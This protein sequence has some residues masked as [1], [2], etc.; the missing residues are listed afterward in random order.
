MHASVVG[1]AGV[2]VGT[3]VG[4]GVGVGVGVAHGAQGAARASDA[5]FVAYEPVVG[6]GAEVFDAF[7][8]DVGE[9][10]V[11]G[12]RFV[13]I[14][15]VGR[16]FG[17]AVCDFMAADIECHERSVVG[18]VA[19]AIGHA[20]T[21]PEGVD[22]VGRV[23]DVG[24]QLGSVAVVGVAVVLLQVVGVHLLGAPMS[25]HADRI[26]REVGGRA[27]EV[28]G[29]VV[30]GAVVEVIGFHAVAAARLA[31]AIDGAGVVGREGD[32]AVVEAGAGGGHVGVVDA[33]VFEDHMAREGIDEHPGAV[34]GL[35]GIDV[36][37]PCQTRGRLARVVGQDDEFAFRQIGCVLL[38]HPL[39]G[40]YVGQG[41]FE[42]LLFV[43]SR[44]HGR[45]GHVYHVG[46]DGFHLSVAHV[47]REGDAL[48][49]YLLIE[50]LVLFMVKTQG[51]VPLPYQRELFAGGKCEVVAQYPLGGAVLK[52]GLYPDDVGVLFRVK[53]FLGMCS[54]CGKQQC[55][56]QAGKR[57]K[58]VLHDEPVLG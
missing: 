56:C 50:K 55:E 53:R 52:V 10:L 20:R 13:L 33:R 2:P 41:V 58:E 4:V 21:V 38:P 45:A 42:R 57:G 3:A 12:A 24:Q 28:G 51:I 8:E 11:E 44:L 7:A 54:A 37:F 9:R 40:G 39:G 27:G 6:A 26:G 30:V 18:T 31:Q 15:E 47:Q 36:E 16:I 48:Y 35:H 19:V 25:L 29:L 34:E 32:V 5:D 14:D 23:V 43:N 1:R 17:D 49:R 46:A 22:V